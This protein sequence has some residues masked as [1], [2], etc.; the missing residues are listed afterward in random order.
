MSQPTNLANNLPKQVIEYLVKKGY[1]RTEQMLRLE[2][3]NLDKEGKP[4]QDRAEDFGTAKY[5]RGFELLSHWINQNLDIY[6]VSSQRFDSDLITL[7]YFSVRIKKIAMAY[8]RLFL[9]G[10]Y[11]EWIFYRWRGVPKEIQRKIRE[12]SR[13][14]TPR[15]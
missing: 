11:N 12:S 9:S 5:T 6:K 14:R 13:R 3:A 1:N 8:L 10:A 7:M 2:S 15:L 4:I